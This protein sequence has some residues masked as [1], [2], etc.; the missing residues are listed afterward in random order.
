MRTEMG[1]V[2]AKL[3]RMDA[4]F[5]GLDARLDRMDARFDGLDARL[6]RMDGRFDRM[7]ARFDAVLVA[8]R[9]LSPHA[10]LA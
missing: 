3:D 6:D 1:E 5:D 10:P 4:R 9:A 8:I 2:R 7:D